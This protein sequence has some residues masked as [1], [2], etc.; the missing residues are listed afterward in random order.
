MAAERQ[1]SVRRRGIVSRARDVGDELLGG[2][3]LGE[4]KALDLIAALLLQ[5]ALLLLL[6]VVLVL[7]LLMLLGSW[8]MAT[9]RSFRDAG[10]KK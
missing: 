2:Q 4:Q 8:R 10:V 5:E 6:V 7:L 3:G 9:K 1:G